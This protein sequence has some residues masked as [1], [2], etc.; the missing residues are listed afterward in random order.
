LLPRRHCLL[1]SLGGLVV[2]SLPHLLPLPFSRVDVSYQAGLTTG[3][4]S[5]TTSH[6]EQRLSSH[7]SHVFLVPC[8][9]M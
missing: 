5:L 1:C 7:T 4:R 8:R 9:H 6:V 2:G 3:A